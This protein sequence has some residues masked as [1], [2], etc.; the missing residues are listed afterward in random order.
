MKI[1][2]PFR[3]KHGIVLY[4][5]LLLLVMLC[6]SI[7]SNAR[8]TGDYSGGKI[9]ATYCDISGDEYTFTIH[10]SSGAK[11]KKPHVMLSLDK[12]FSRI[13]YI[14]E[15]SNKKSPYTVTV[16][17]SDIES[18]TYYW[19]AADA[20]GNMMVSSDGPMMTLGS[21]QPV[22]YDAKVDPTVY[23]NVSL[24]DETE[25]SLESV[26]LRTENNGN[27]ME[28]ANAPYCGK[29][30]IFKAP[31]EDY[32]DN[33]GVVVRNNVIYIARGTY[34]VSN[35]KYDK[36]QVW[37]DRYDLASGETLPMLR[38][39][40]DDGNDY[41]STD[42]MS[43]IGEDADGTVYF[44]SSIV[45]DS[46]SKIQ[47]YTVD[48]D[49]IVSKDGYE[50]ALSHLEGEFTVPVAPKYMRFLIVRGS[51]KSGNY[52]LWGA[53]GKNDLEPL[54]TFEVPV[55]RWKVE[56][57]TTSVK[58]VKIKQFATVDVRNAYEVRIISPKV[59]PISDDMFYF[60]ARP[61]ES[62]VLFHP[63]LYRVPS[64]NGDV[65]E[66]V[67][68]LSDAGKSL[69]NTMA[70]SPFGVSLM[71]VNDLPIL[72]YGRRADQGSSVQLLEMS[73]MDMSFATAKPL[74]NINPDGFSKINVQGCNL[75]YIP[76][77]ENSPTGNLVVY[78]PNGGLGLYRLT[79]KGTTVGIDALFAL[80]AVDV[81]GRVVTLPYECRDI[82][83]VDMSGRTCL[84]FERGV[85][86]DASSLSAGVYFI[87]SPTLDSPCKVLLK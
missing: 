80:T 53:E 18:A 46:G 11:L 42:L 44:T 51:I 49:N 35:W 32:T 39:R 61:F 76:D 72:A 75:V 31:S 10:P 70:E 73:P 65:C 1:L 16:K 82:R 47:L 12:D 37:I 85:S 43:L 71:Y 52:T 57:G 3:A 56:N 45:D 23:D 66:M 7:S 84:R 14:F 15:L 5:S 50:I 8:I 83:M 34:N 30:T 86:L 36:E 29:T 55:Y 77:N 38:V 64:D 6:L 58:A 79:A 87:V 40:P 60:H 2:S 41:V 69:H 9:S 33:H 20:D 24:A 67:T 4:R 78:V 63:A 81:R 19:R 17:S 59:M 48:L 13:K 21:K 27:R 54:T 68:S 28:W 22:E 62:D 26:W 25:L 74:W